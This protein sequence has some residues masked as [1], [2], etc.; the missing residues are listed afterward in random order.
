MKERLEGEADFIQFVSHSILEDLSELEPRDLIPDWCIAADSS[1]HYVPM[2]LQEKMTI[3]FYRGYISVVGAILEVLVQEANDSSCVPT[4]SAIN[5]RL[6]PY[7]AYVHSFFDAGGQITYA[8]EALVNR[9]YEKSPEGSEYRRKPALQEEEAEFE[10]DTQE[11]PRC[12]HDLD[13]TLLR[14]RLGLE[15]EGHGPHW[16]FLTDDEDSDEAEED[17]E[18]VYVGQQSDVVTAEKK[19]T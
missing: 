1:L 15:L 13:F 14:T 9:A 3:A 17:E 6:E 8:V 7:P 5:A 16:F 11:L 12:V 19:A 10:K 18:A 4:T 2:E